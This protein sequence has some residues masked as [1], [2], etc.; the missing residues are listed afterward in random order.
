MLPM[1]TQAIHFGASGWQRIIAKDFT[2]PGVRRSCAAIA[3]QVLGQKKNPA[4]VADCGTRLFCEEFARTSAAVLG[5]EGRPILLCNDATPGPAV[6]HA[7]IH[8]KLD[9]GVYTTATG[10]GLKFSG[11]EGGPALL[12][13]TKDIERRAKR[14][15]LFDGTGLDPLEENLAPLKKL[16]LE[17]KS[18]A[19]RATDA[20]ADGSFMGGEESAG[21]TIRADVPE[22]D[23]L[24][25]RLLV[26]EMM[27]GRRVAAINRGG[28]QLIFDG[29]DGILVRPSGSE[30]LSSVYAEAGSQTQ[31]QKLSE[32]ARAGIIQ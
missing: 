25:A 32:E 12:E 1:T 28:G 11:P 14:D 29:S 21:R 20:D 23:G 24:L 9:S 19:A 15:V 7:L 17:N 22:K 6:A 18:P 5:T 26:G 10:N 27:A 13:V 4:L 2:F 16:V 3:G 30:P 8:G 31:S